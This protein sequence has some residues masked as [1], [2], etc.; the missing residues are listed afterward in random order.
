MN[1]WEYTVVSE[2]SG[3]CNIRGPS[4]DKSGSSSIQ[5]LN[6]LGNQ[7]WEV[8]SMSTQPLE[9]FDFKS[10]ILKRLRT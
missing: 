10:Y 5:A 8:V 3:G 2:H 6:E 9:F 4:G 7:G 1:R